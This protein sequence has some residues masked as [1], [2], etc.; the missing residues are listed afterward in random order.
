VEYRTFGTDFE[1]PHKCM[2]DMRFALL[3]E[4]LRQVVPLIDSAR[5]SRIVMLH[6]A[7]ARF[8]KAL[9]CLVPPRLDILNRVLFQCEIHSP[10]DP[11][12]AMQN[13]ARTFV[14][15]IAMAGLCTT[16]VI[17]SEFSSHYFSQSEWSLLGNLVR[18]GALMYGSN[19]DYSQT[20]Q[21]WIKDGRVIATFITYAEFDGDFSD[22][23]LRA[24]DPRIFVEAYVAGN[25]V[26]YF[27]P[28]PAI[29]QRGWVG[30]PDGGVLYHSEVAS[31]K[32]GMNVYRFGWLPCYDGH[33][34]R[35]HAALGFVNGERQL[36]LTERVFF[37]RKSWCAVIAALWARLTC[38][39]APVPRYAD[40]QRMVDD[41][42]EGRVV[43]CPCSRSSFGIDML[44]LDVNLVAAVMMNISRRSDVPTSSALNGEIL[45]VFRARY[46]VA[47]REQLP[48]V[49][50][51]AIC[52]STH[53]AV[54]ALYN[55]PDDMILPRVDYVSRP[56]K[57]F[58]FPT[59]GF[60]W[61]ILPTR[62]IHRDVPDWWCE[63]S[64]SM[65]D[66]TRNRKYPKGIDVSF[67]TAKIPACRNP[68]PLIAQLGGGLWVKG[69]RVEP[70]AYENCLHNKYAALAIRVLPNTQAYTGFATAKEITA[71]LPTDRAYRLSAI[72]TGPPAREMTLDYPVSLPPWPTPTEDAIRLWIS[73]FEKKR[74][75]VYLQLLSKYSSGTFDYDSIVADAMRAL[76]MKEM[77][78]TVSQKGDEMRLGQRPK[79]R[80]ICAV[81]PI[82]GLAFGLECTYVG[83]ALLKIFDGTRPLRLS[84]R[85]VYITLG[86]GKKEEDFLF[87]TMADAGRVPVSGFWLDVVNCDSLQLRSYIQAMFV[88]VV[89]ILERYGV[90]PSAAWRVA[91][92]TRAYE[93]LKL[94]LSD[95]DL[96]KLGLANVKFTVEPQLPSGV[97]ETT[98]SNSTI[99]A[100]IIADIMSFMYPLGTE[101]DI[102]CAGDDLVGLATNAPLGGWE[103]VERRAA[104]VALKLEGSFVDIV[105]NPIELQFCAMRASGVWPFMSWVPEAH[106]RLATLF[107]AMIPTNMSREPEFVAGRFY[108]KFR[109]LYVG[110][111]GTPVF[112]DIVGAVLPILERLPRTCAGVKE[113]VHPDVHKF[114]LAASTPYGDDGL[115]QFCTYYGI[116]EEL[117]WDFKRELPAMAAQL[118]FEHPIFDQI[119]ER[120]GYIVDGKW[121]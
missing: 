92:A 11:E 95:R 97:F 81:K 23:F 109:G 93:R 75:S 116:D 70:F 37:T 85:L 28:A 100:V 35:I 89:D 91:F 84:G 8:A 94:T 110:S 119:F 98:I 34:L 52:R 3:V 39:R 51:L 113:E 83:E 62:C 79:P 77:V 10:G 118:N 102:G 49:L 53:H 25:P 96:E 74:R 42:N 66:L 57:P 4:M 31:S 68:I 106:R 19:H 61:G 108:E 72:L 104:G 58:V 107:H 1:N 114:Y 47:G 73:R 29:A 40:Y 24:V 21:T 63:L 9:G 56:A 121:R 27:H 12:R 45:R 60:S 64:R 33:A 20:V 43:C 103:A 80:V 32:S 82:I 90:H 44:A 14:G 78:A 16:D 69:F 55:G 76:G 22:D 18:D 17:L 2:A 120:V 5:Y 67:L 54:R 105:N 101:I 26:G 6:A 50:K 59:R 7:P 86:Y 36:F 115:S 71:A 65:F 46:E 48:D 117:F 30:L 87:R 15:S 99:T 38:R 13:P 41:R 88:G 111:R 112:G